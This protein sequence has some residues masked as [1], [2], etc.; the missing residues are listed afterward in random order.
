MA[1]STFK[2]QETRGRRFYGLRTLT[3]PPSENLHHGYP[4][5]MNLRRRLAAGLIDA[6]GALQVHDP[7]D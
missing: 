2:R 1:R 7:F 3:Y 5:Q 4:E 6:E